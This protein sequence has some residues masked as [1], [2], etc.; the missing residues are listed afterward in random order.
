MTGVTC[1]QLEAASLERGELVDLVQLVDLD[2]ELLG[3]V[4]VVRRQLVLGVVAAADVALAARNA[5]AKYG[6]SASTPGLP[7]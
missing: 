1:V 4:E 5:S 2:A 7:K 6:S 3:Q